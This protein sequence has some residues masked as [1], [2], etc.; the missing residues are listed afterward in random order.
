V[1]R[2]ID[3]NFVEDE[4]TVVRESG[5]SIRVVFVNIV[6]ASSDSYQW[7][8]DG[9]S[10]PPSTQE[11]D[12]FTGLIGYSGDGSMIIYFAATGEKPG[13][14]IQNVEPGIIIISN[15]D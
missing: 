4:L 9:V 2:L 10:N 13:P 6:G 8:I 3:G 11:S 14:R 7:I 1:P 5:S 12:P 15:L